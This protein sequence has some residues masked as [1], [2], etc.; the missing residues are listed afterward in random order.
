MYRAC[1]EG[2]VLCREVYSI[3]FFESWLRY[4]TL[5]VSD[6]ILAR[7]PTFFGVSFI[8]GFTISL[9]SPN[10][11]VVWVVWGGGGGGGGGGSS[12]LKNCATS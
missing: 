6:A 7:S 11:A 2:I 1:I 5:A 8:G 12:H 10:H 9:R 3:N 4:S